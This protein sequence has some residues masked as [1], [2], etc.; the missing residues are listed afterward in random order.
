MLIN[1]LKINKKKIGSI[2]LA[3]NLL[4]SNGYSEIKSF[5][6]MATLKDGR[7]VLIYFQIDNFSLIEIN[8]SL[9]FVSNSL[10]NY[11]HLDTNNDYSEINMF[12]KVNNPC[13]IYNHPSSNND[14]IIDVIDKDI[15]VQVLAKNNDGWYVIYYNSQIGFIN[16]MYLTNINTQVKMAKITGNNVNIRS[17]P[18][19]NYDIIGFSDTTDYFKIIGEKNDWY[20][21]NYLNE[22]GYVSKKYA[23]EVLKNQDDINYESIV[24]LTKDSLFYKN[25]NGEVYTY[26]PKYQ[27]AFVICKEKDFYKVMVDGIIGYISINDTKKLSNTCIIIDLPRQMLRLYKDT[28]EIGRFHIITG[29]EELKTTI[30]CF[31]IGHLIKGYQLTPE[32]Y[33]NYWIQYN[34]NEGI[35]D[36]LWQ[37]EKR[38]YDNAKDA[39]NNYTNGKNILFP[40]KYGSHGCSNMMLPD[41]EKV[42]NMVNTSCNVLVIGLNNLIDFIKTNKEIDKDLTKIKKLI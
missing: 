22:E 11:E 29:R 7:N 37:D 36:A 41:A 21:I 33:V 12:M 25:M 4:F 39:Y 42:F 26:L 18:S 32:N 31:K 35:H 24:Y 30:G 3:F 34:G 38:F 5:S 40:K 14:Y 2:I 8:G 28:K 19:T 20:K 9:F 16:E 17:G 15:E 27:N 10:V 13:Y 23:C 1:N 6:N